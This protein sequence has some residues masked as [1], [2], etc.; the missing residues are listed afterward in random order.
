MWTSARIN[1][2]GHKAFMFNSSGSSSII[3]EA[4]MLLPGQ[5]G[6]WPAFWM[7][8]V[9]NSYGPWCNRQVHPSSIAAARNCYGWYVCKCR[10]L[11]IHFVRNPDMRSWS[12]CSVAHVLLTSLH[13]ILQWRDRHH[14]ADQWSKHASLHHTFWIYIPDIHLQ[15]GKRHHSDPGSVTVACL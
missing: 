13:M 9:P 3:V 8:P 12:L 1:T 5:P 4:R 11:Y 6:T 15:Q 7:L 2:Q 10:T 14:G